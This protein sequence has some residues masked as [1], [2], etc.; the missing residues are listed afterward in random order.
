MY[1]RQVKELIDVVHRSS[2]RYDYPDNIFGYGIT[3]MWK[4][5]RIGQEMKSK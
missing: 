3:D 2:D 4:A 5:Y 1:K